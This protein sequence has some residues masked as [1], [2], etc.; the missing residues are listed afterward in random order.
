MLGTGMVGVGG[1]IQQQ[2][3]FDQAG[4]P[5][6]GFAGAGQAAV[7]RPVNDMPFSSRM[8]A[9][10]QQEQEA[11]LFRQQMLAPMSAPQDPGYA[12]LLLQLRLQEQEER[13]RNQAFAMGQG[14]W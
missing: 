5:A 4:V 10:A 14:R 2:F 1:G 9:Y 12:N 3:L 11:A 6:M 8:D 7:G 13:M